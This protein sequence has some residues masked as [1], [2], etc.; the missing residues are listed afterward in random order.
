MRV[1]QFLKDH[2]AA[3]E[4][5]THAPA[6]TA[7]K[8]ARFLHI[9]GRQV[10]KSVLLACEGRFVLAVL[11]A[12]DHIKLDAVASEM[13]APTRL[14]SEAEMM[15]VF[16][17]CEHGA[18]APFGSLYGVTTLLE[19]GIDPSATIVFESQQHAVTIK[20]RCRDFEALERPRRFRFKMD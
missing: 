7:Q 16:R 20:M 19:D 12:A 14:A 5:L 17:D 8:R 1:A 13:G 18:L 3:F 4:A 15:S 6:Y 10:V 11:P 2:D 9:S